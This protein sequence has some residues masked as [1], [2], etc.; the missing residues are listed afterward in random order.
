MEYC[1]NRLDNVEYI[2]YHTIMLPAGKVEREAGGEQGEE[3]GG[4]VQVGVDGLGL[5]VDVEVR[6]V[7][8]HQRVQLVHAQAQLRHARLEHFPHSVVLHY[9]DQHCER[10]FLWHLQ[11]HYHNQVALT[12]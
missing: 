12:F 5:E 1:D 9:L 10:V 8:L 4:G 11:Y 2:F 7:L 3:P 6:D